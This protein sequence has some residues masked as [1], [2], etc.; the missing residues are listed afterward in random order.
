MRHATFSRAAVGRSQILPAL[1]APLLA[2]LFAAS[3]PAQIVINE[4][5]AD[6]NAAL[7]DEDG[8]FPDWLEIYNPS[9]AD[10]NLAGWSLSVTNLSSTPFLLQW[11]FP[12]TNLPAGGF[13]VIFAS[14]KNRAVAG[15]PLHT[16]FK[17]SKS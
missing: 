13:M 12:A 14:E 1:L 5:M 4:V 9:G 7:A 8:A 3:A 2:L 17:I 11:S 16:N 6:N 10:V 15:A